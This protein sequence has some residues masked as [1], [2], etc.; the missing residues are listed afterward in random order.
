MQQADVLD[1]LIGKL[2]H[3]VS[4]AWGETFAGSPEIDVDGYKRLQRLVNE[5]GEET[6]RRMLEFAYEGKI[7]PR[8]KNG[9]NAYPVA[10]TLCASIRR[11]SIHE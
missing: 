4:P 11:N 1:A 9:H 10:T 2:E 5:H 8:T 7:R 6:V 3:D